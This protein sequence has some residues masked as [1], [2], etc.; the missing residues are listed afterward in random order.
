MKITKEIHLRSFEAWIC[1]AF[2]GAVET[3]EALT[4]EQK[5]ELEA[6]LEELFPDGM[7][8]TDLNDF[9]WFEN[10]SIAELLGF[11]DWEDLENSGEE[12]DEEE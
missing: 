1:P 12:E 6:S 4:D 7:D 3:L 11:D 9:L 8:E 5:D 2:G 10:D